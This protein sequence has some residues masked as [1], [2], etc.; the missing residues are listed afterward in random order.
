MRTV[1]F[2]IPEINCGHCTSSIEG[3][4]KDLAGVQSVNTSVEDKTAT[5]QFTEEM[6]TI[7]A[8]IEAIDDV[9][10]TATEK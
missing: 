2:N 3:A 7:T 1:T 8:I 9:G 10:F 5:V 6:I 4:L